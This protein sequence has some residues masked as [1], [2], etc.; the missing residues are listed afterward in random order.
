M[1]FASNFKF[2]KLN[3]ARTLHPE[4]F[5]KFEKPEKALNESSNE[6]S[7]SHISRL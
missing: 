1:S 7:F 4:E 3:Q 6:S 5:E 2:F